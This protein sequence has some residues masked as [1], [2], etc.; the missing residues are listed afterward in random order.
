[1]ETM[2]MT[3]REIVSRLDEI[4]GKLD[5]LVIEIERAESIWESLQ[6]CSTDSNFTPTWLSGP[7]GCTIRGVSGA[8]EAVPARVRTKSTDHTARP[9]AAGPFELRL[10]V[11]HA[12]LYYRHRW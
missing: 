3:Q 10:S 7:A 9:R 2:K 5:A 11:R 12:H 8:V 6:H 1:M 4:D